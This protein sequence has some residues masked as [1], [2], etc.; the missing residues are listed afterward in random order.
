MANLSFMEKQVICRLFGISDGFVFKFWSDHGLYNKTI[1]KDMILD[2]CGIDIYRDE[3]YKKLS[4]QK[5][6]QRI[7]DEESPQTV[8]NLLK[9]LISYF[10]FQ[11]EGDCWDDETQSDYQQVQS[12]INRLESIDTLDLPKQTERQ[13]IQLIMEDIEANIRNGKPELIIDRLHTFSVDFFRT[14]CKKHGIVTEDD[15]GSEFPLHSLVGRLK[16]WYAENHYFDSEFSVVAIQNTINIFDKYNTIRNDQSAAH[17]NE[18]LNK[19]KAMYAVRIVAETLTFIDKIE[20][21]KD[22]DTSEPRF[23]WDGLDDDGELPF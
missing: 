12:I 7:W 19:A 8:A 5:C 15:R 22:E 23:L 2:A 3:E 1:T 4:Q 20:R 16:N 13:S 10:H 21:I 17:P 14:L 9:A 18:M 11:M 6:I